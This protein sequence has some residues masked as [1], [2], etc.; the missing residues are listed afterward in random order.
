MNSTIRAV[1]LMLRRIP[2]FVEARFDNRFLADDV[3]PP[4]KVTH[5]NWQNA[6]LELANVKGARVLEVGSREVTGKSSFRKQFSKA[7]YIGFD[8]YSGSNVDIVGDA[9]KLSSYFDPG[10]EFDLIF[11]SA[12]FEHFAMPWV[13]SQEIC[14]LL[15]VGGHVFVE[16]HFSYSSHERPWN[17]FQ[18]SDMGLRVLFNEQLGIT[19]VDSG[20]CNPIVGRFSSLAD[21]Y[22]RLTPVPALYCHSA[23]LGKK[24]KH[25]A[26]FSWDRASVENLVSGTTYPKPAVHRD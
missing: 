5:A 3:A 19:P 21:P 6:L 7:E 11:S 12:S 4:R 10:T 26:D 24:T 15:R 17:F 14:K 16:T 18:F 9:H 23:F 1:L 13:V 22:L 20:M 2:L 8:Y 25:V